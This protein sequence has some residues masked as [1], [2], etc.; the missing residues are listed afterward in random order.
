MMP[1][2]ASTMTQCE[3]TEWIKIA[4]LLGIGLF[5]LTLLVFGIGV[6]A[7]CLFENRRDRHRGTT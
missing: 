1:S 6:L 3:L 5:S 2:L 7:K 4:V